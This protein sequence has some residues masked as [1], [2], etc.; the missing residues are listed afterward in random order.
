MPITNEILKNGTIRGTS[1][2][3]TSTMD[4]YMNL[5][6]AIV[7]Q[8]AIDIRENNS[9]A[10]SAK[11]FFKSKWFNVLTDL[12]GESILEKLQEEK[13]LEEKIA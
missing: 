2:R 12:D 11:S 7:W 1:M 4:P 9:H 13:H 6:T 3:K 10:K 5:A 8:A